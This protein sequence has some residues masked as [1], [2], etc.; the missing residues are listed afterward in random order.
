MLNDKDELSPIVKRIIDAS[1]V[2]HAEHTINASTFTAMV[3]ASTLAHPVQVI[4]SAIGSL[5]GPTW[6]C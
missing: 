2:L 5:S 1:L 6:R 4:A 3:T